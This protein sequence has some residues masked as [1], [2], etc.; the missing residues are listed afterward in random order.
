MATPAYTTDLAD[1]IADSDTTSWS[2]L[3]GMIS[4]GGPD[5]SDT[6]SA[7]QGINTVSQAT[8]TTNLFSMCRILGTPVTIN[9]GDV[10]LVWHGHGV[11]TSLLTYANGGLRLVNADSTSDWKAWAV[12]GNDVPP[13]PY[14]KWVNTPIDTTITSEYSNGTPPSGL[15]ITGI[16]SAGQLS[17]NVAKGQP[18]ICDMIRYGRAEA[19]MNGGEAADYATFAGFATVNDYNDVTNGYNRWGL[20]QAVS[21]G[22]LWKGL[23]ILGY[24]TVVDFRDSN[25]TIFIQDCRKV[26]DGFN[27]IEIRQSG[28]RVDWTNIT[29]NNVSP[30]T[31]ASAGA[32]EMVDNADVNIDSCS[33]IDMSTFIFLSNATINNSLFLRSDQITHGGAVFSGCVFNSYEG[34]AGTAYLTYNIAADP[35][36]E[37]DNCSFIKGTASTHAI[38]FGTST[39]TTIT[40][41]G[42]D[43][44]GYNASHEQNDSTLRFLH[45]SGTITVNLVGCTGNISYKKEVGAT[46]NL[47]INP[48]ALTI[49]MKRSD[50]KAAIQ[51]V[52]VT[53]WAGAT[54]NLPYQDSVTIVQSGGTATVTHTA[55]GLAT[56]DKVEIKGANENNYNRIKTITVTGADAYTYPIDS[57]TSSPATGTITSTAIIINALTN[58]SGQVSDTRSY[59][60]DQSYT[61]K[62][63]K[64]TSEPVFVDAPVDG[65]IDKDAGGA[66][67][68]FMISD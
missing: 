38:E 2:E 14:G 64:G 28:S 5:E 51:D 46:I 22:Y 12:G 19:R 44:S 27:K 31:N 7:L 37:M 60:A 10:F 48:V 16:G 41:T 67:T 3:T 25:K 50:T 49:T 68:V 54:G 11:A 20:I 57:G 24:T 43:F 42:I 32:F 45:T 17:A 66:V 39:P 58:V 30:S 55:H 59:T 40:L 9:T 61:G 29:F 33:F 18:H 35:N 23:M 34:T 13:F 36:G 65:T 1:W 63:Q 52:A 56:G 6:E 47:V 4:G 8:N 26:Y 62:G 53:V 15:S 21:G